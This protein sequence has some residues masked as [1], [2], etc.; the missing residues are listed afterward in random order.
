[1][2]KTEMRNENSKHFDKLS[3]IDMVK[4][5]NHENAN[6]VA[7]VEAAAEQIAEA[8]DAISESVLKLMDTEKERK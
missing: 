1:M 2:Q 4:V 6:A 8:I 5:M 3:T 7:A